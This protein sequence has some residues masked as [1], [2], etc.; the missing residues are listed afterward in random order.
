[1]QHPS[2]SISNTVSVIYSA[3]FKERKDLLQEITV[4]T[5]TLTKYIFNFRVTFFK[6]HQ[7]FPDISE[8]LENKTQTPQEKSAK[9]KEKPTT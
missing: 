7:V 6:Q 9:I 5:E 1:M 8:K 2:N 3:G 4:A